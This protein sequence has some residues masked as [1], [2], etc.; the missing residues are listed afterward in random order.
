MSPRSGKTTKQKLIDTATALFLEKGV[1]R[2]GVREIA[3]TAGINLSLMNYY[4]RS[5]EI[6]FET[7]FEIQIKERAHLLRVIL[8]SE[9][10]LENKIREYVSTYIDVLLD[11]PLL[12]SFV[13]SIVHRSP[14]TIA[15]MKVIENLYHTESFMEQLRKE[16]EAGNIKPIDAEQFFLSMI[17]L[18]LFP[19]AIQPL[20]Q[21]RNRINNEQFRTMMRYRKE[22]VFQAL[23]TSIKN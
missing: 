18:V 15:K 1:D 17:S 2:V 14:D 6:L 20:I 4:F 9:Q 7:I 19:F 21:D 16:S 12:V 11:N 23:W 10:T 8:D 22:H 13:M 3:A 5:K